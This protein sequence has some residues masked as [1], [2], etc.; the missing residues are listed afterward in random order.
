MGCTN[1]PVKFN[2]NEQTSLDKSLKKYNEIEHNLS[3]IDQKTSIDQSNLEISKEDE[4][5]K[6]DNI[7]SMKEL[8]ALVNIPLEAGEIFSI[9]FKLEKIKNDL[10]EIDNE[11]NKLSNLKQ[12]LIETKLNFEKKLKEITKA[13]NVV[14]IGQREKK[15][16]IYK[17]IFIII[18]ILCIVAFICY[19][20]TSI[21]L[22]ITFKKYKL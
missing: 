9:D 8:G 17:I 1:N 15:P 10:V 4:N 19:L 18:I 11:I 13:N 12:N 3:L 2:S 20:L 5:I 7:F 6:I 16:E 14:Y 22:K 21:I